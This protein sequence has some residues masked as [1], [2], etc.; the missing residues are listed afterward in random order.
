MYGI[1]KKY[2]TYYAKKLSKEH[3]NKGMYELRGKGQL[4]F[5]VN[6]LKDL[7]KMIGIGETVQIVD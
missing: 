6:T 7:E 5:L 3:I 4:I 2:E 1:Y